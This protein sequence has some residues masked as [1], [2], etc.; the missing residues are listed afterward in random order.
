MK[1]DT[2]YNQVEKR[3]L[4]QNASMHVYFEEVATECNARGVTMRMM[5]EYTDIEHTPESIKMFWKQIAK[6]K[7]GKEKTSQMTSKEI[8]GVYEEFNKMLAHFDLQVSFPSQTNSDSYL[9]SLD[10]V[11]H[12]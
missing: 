11:I 10:S 2:T 12:S 4:K 7:Y 5:T 8:D 9:S 6:I 1:D 3:S